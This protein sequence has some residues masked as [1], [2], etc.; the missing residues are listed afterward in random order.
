MFGFLKKNIVKTPVEISENFTD[1]EPLLTYFRLQTGICFK[2]RKEIIRAKVINFSKNRGFFDF[3]SLLNN[4]K[5]D[6]ILKQELIDYLTVN[7]TYFYREIQE[8]NQLVKKIKDSDKKVKILCAPSSTGEEPYTIAISLL[9]ENICEK[10]F[11]ITAIDI[12][13]DVIKDAKKAIYRERS[14]HKVSLYIRETYFF[15]N[16]G[17]YCLKNEIKKLVD[18]KIFNIFDES[19]L[20]L[21]KFDYIFSRNMLIYF[22]KEKKVEAKNILKSLLKNEDEKIFFGHA[23]KY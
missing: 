1:I 2:N 23:D 13:S 3:E 20:K 9:Q 21:G 12:N 5:V 19:I 18:F 10:R 15:K 6:L 22:D 17:L 16:N 8:I 7:E 4:L 14:L 11:T